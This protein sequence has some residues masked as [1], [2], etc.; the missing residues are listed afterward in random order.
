MNRCFLPWPVRPFFPG[1]KQRLVLAR[2][3]I[4][5]YDKPSL[6]MISPRG[7]GHCAVIIAMP[8][9]QPK[10]S[11]EGNGAEAPLRLHG[12]S[13]DDLP[14]FATALAAVM[15]PGDVL[16]L[17]GGLGAGKTTLTQH[18]ARAL[19]VGDDQYVSS[20]SFALLHEYNGRMPVAHLD[21]YR[22]HGEEEVEAAGLLEALDQQGVIIVEWP[23]R[24]GSLAPPDRLDIHLAPQPQDRRT[25]TLTPVGSGWRRRLD[26]LTQLLGDHR[27]A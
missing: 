24:M 22:L 14:R 21:L 9:S 8:D 10:A 6:A 7:S 18:L 25:L 11:V 3:M 16:F 1:C 15:T 13:L 2:P 23:E 5:S 27:S 20:P 12:L 4:P 26:K 17:S 19:G